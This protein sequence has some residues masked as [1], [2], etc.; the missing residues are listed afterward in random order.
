MWREWENVDFIPEMIVVGWRTMDGRDDWPEFQASE[1]WQPS[2]CC[3][4]SEW[5]MCVILCRCIY[6]N[7]MRMVCWNYAIL[8]LFWYQYWIGCLNVLLLLIGDDAGS[9]LIKLCTNVDTCDENIWWILMRTYDDVDENIWWF[10][11]KHL[12]WCDCGKICDWILYESFWR[13]CQI[14]MWWN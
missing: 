5:S 1:W 14:W 12:M 7:M 11:W 10:W 3:F 8:P 4:D 2:V 13:L 9:V 6:V